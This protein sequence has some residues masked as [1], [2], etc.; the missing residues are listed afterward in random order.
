M[1][2]LF[3]ISTIFGASVIA[4]AGILDLPFTPEEK[5]LYDKGYVA[6]LYQPKL[7]SRHEIG[8][9]APVGKGV[10]HSHDNDPVLF[11][12]FG[13]EDASIA[14]EEGK[15]MAEFKYTPAMA[16]QFLFAQGWDKYHDRFFT[17]AYVQEGMDAYTKGR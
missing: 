10:N 4:K 8:K 13:I 3:L 12:I 6:E 1:K 7:H 15:S 9:L 2:K 5:A 11:L 17:R 14:R 16:E